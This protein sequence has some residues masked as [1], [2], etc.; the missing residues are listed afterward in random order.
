M[1][2]PRLLHSRALHHTPD[3]RLATSAQH[4]HPAP[5]LERLLY[6]STARQRLGSLHLLSLLTTPGLRN[7]ALDITGHLLYFNGKFV[8]YL[9]GPIHQRRFAPW[10]ISLS[11]DDAL[12]VHGTTGFFPADQNGPSPRLAL[13]QQ[14]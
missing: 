10:S 4:R 12:C 13:C 7:S 5:G 8:Q 3:T 2:V 14:N 9:E 1:N 6:Q 11:S